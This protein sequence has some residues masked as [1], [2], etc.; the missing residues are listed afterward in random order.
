MKPVDYSGLGWALGRMKNHPRPQGDR[1]LR[2]QAPR[3][4]SD[5]DAVL[6]RSQPPVPLAPFSRGTYLWWRTRAPK[7]EYLKSDLSRVSG[8]P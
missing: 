4:P 1:F 8:T 5:E 6:P 7:V 2:G 3:G